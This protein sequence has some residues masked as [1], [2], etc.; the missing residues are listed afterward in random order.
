M[1]SI[2]TAPLESATSVKAYSNRL[3]EVFR[4]GNGLP[5]SDGTGSIWFEPR[6]F[7]LG[8]LK[9]GFPW[10]LQ[11]EAQAGSSVMTESYWSRIPGVLAP[12]NAG[13]SVDLDTGS[14]TATSVF[15][16]SGQGSLDPDGTIISSFGRCIAGRSHSASAS[17]RSGVE[18]RGGVSRGYGQVLIQG[19][20]DTVTSNSAISVRRGTTEIWSVGYDGAATFRASV[21]A[22]DLQLVSSDPQLYRSTPAGDEY[23]GPSLSLV[24]E[25]VRLEALVRELY[26]KLRLTPPAGWD[27]WDGNSDLVK[28]RGKKKGHI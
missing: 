28:S 27:V 14:L 1:L 3:G 2:D 22:N 6:G 25:I 9:A 24:D 20:S 10:E 26:D 15:W 19:P 13:D 4:L 12:S 18:L 17:D 21:T 16:A 11:F 23:V 7:N 8:W 5:P